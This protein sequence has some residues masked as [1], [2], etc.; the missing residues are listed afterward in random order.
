VAVGGGVTGQVAHRIVAA[1][2]GLQPGS[3]NAVLVSHAFA[4]SC[5]VAPCDHAVG[6]PGRRSSAERFRAAE[7]FLAIVERFRAVLQVAAQLIFLA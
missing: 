5:S 4:S 3:E 1:A 6:D 7:R 2:L